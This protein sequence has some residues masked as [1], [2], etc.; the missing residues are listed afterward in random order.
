MAATRAAWTRESCPT[1]PRHRPT[2]VPHARATCRGS[3][4]RKPASPRRGGCGCGLCGSSS[5]GSYPLFPIP[6]DV[7]HHPQLPDRVAG[8]EEE[9]TTW[10][11][12][13]HLGDGLRRHSD[14]IGSTPVDRQPP[15]GV[16]V[17]GRSGADREDRTAVSAPCDRR[18]CSRNE[19]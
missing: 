12:E 9:T 15:D 3:G 8:D 17:P 14:G 13:T 6:K 2:W 1:A 19:R 4:R 11:I 18:V 16:Q 7:F 10:G 5:D